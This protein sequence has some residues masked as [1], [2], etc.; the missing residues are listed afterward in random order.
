MHA[1]FV[2][3]APSSHCS[4]DSRMPLPQ[5]PQSSGQVVFVS[6]FADWQ[7]L[8]PQYVPITVLIVQLVEHVEHVSGGLLYAGV[9]HAV[10]VFATPLSH[11]SP[12]S[13]MPLPQPEQSA[14]QVV[15]V[16]PFAP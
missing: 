11:S 9:E 4:P 12:V 7:M 15:L 5:P 3:S 16:S 14:G 6:P 13:T 10:F 1:V 8:S 2:L